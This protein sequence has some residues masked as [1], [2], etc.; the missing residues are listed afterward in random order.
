[1]RTLN[2]ACGLILGL[3][4]TATAGAAEIELKFGHAASSRHLFH[5]GGEM[6][7]QAVADKTGGRVAVEIVGDRQLGDDR[8]L[9]E[10]IQLGTIDGAI[11][12]SAT[13]PL[14]GAA[15][16]DAL[17][18]PFLVSSYDEL[19]DLLTG[20]I[21]QEL[22]D[23]LSEH[24]MKGLSY[25][26]AGLRH[27]LTRGEPV[28]TIADFAG[29]KTR[30]VPIPLHKETWEAVGTN[31]VG[32]PYGE[33]YSGLETGVIDAVEINVSSIES[34][35]LYRNA[36][37]VTLTGHYF[38][39]GILVIN[40]DRFDSLPED[41]QQAIVEAGHETIAQH[42]ALARDDEAR[43]A[44]FL[45]E[46]GVEIVELG[47]LDEMRARMQ[48]VIDEWA[49]KDPLIRKFIEAAGSGS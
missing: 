40:Q 43:S 4:V 18:L 42:Y 25:Y 33:I 37:N 23:S 15:A 16:I 11:V 6:F 44:D 24:G 28:T 47:D 19:S 27:F 8:Q 9:L 13:F 2:W 14:I 12:S 26:E 3:A 20:D 1:M 29:L 32:M 45:R 17:Q 31:P 49:A 39:P 41:V 34:E 22:L 30:I 38:W 35:S 10:G 7:S 48:P 36:R 46:Q 21:G 5:Q